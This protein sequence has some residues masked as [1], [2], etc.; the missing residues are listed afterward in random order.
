MPFCS[1]CGNEVLLT[2]KFCKNCGAPLQAIKKITDNSVKLEVNGSTH[3]VVIGVVPHVVQPLVYPKSR[4]WTLITT[5]QRILL[6]QFTGAVMQE[7]LAFSKSRAKGLG[8][9]LAGKVLLAPDVVEYCRKY[10]RMSPEQILS[11]TQG[12]L[13]LNL[14]EIRRAFIDYEQEEKDEDSSIQMDRYWLTLVTDQ[15]DYKYVIDADPQDMKVLQE[16]L[17]DRVHGEGRSKAMKP[18]F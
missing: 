15:S 11:E 2:E 12:N 16:A 8:K 14:S 17:G 6:A 1:S 10:F 5:N 9:L 3:E 18:K 13:S 7:A 4:T